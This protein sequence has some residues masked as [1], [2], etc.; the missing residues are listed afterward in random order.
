M[1]STH[2]ARLKRARVA[3]EGLSVG[4]GFGERFFRNGAEILIQN[5]ALPKP[6]WNYTDDTNMALSIYEVLRLHGKIKQDE[7][8]ASFAEHYH[9]LRGYGPAMHGLLARIREGEDWKSAAGSLFSGQGSFG[10]GAAMRVAPLGAYYA[11]NIDAVIEN[12]ALSAEITHAHVEGIAGAIAT[13]VATAYAWRLREAAER[14]TRQEFIDLVI[15]HVPNSIVQMKLRHA[16]NLAESASVMLA[17]SALGNGSQ[18]SAQDTVPFVLWSAGEQLDNFQEAMW[19]T[20]DAYGDIDTNCAMVGGIV[21]SYVGV[22][23]VPA[24]WIASREPLPS[25]AIEEV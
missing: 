20:V 1:D 25:W 23:N 2:E 18:V 22:E 15:P 7:L 14:P 12:A 5:R 21:A 9:M 13:A 16:R 11:D 4:D 19:Q 24:D 8:A 10:N 17:I 3:L 6:E